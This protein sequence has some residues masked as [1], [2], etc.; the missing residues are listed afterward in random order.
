MIVH[1]CVRKYGS[2]SGQGGEGFNFL[3]GMVSIYPLLCQRDVKLKQTQN[4]PE[5]LIDNDNLMDVDE[6]SDEYTDESS[7]EFVDNFPY[8]NDTEADDD[9]NKACSLE[10]L[11]QNLSLVTYGDGF[12]YVCIT[13]INP[14][15]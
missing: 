10:Q 2:N 7:S 8:I 12:V 9:D 6:D 1:H 13:I 3:A 15:D 14:I 11:E 5:I 4:I